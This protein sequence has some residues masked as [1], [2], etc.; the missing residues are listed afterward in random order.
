MKEK[1]YWITECIK[2]AEQSGNRYMTGEAIEAIDQI[3]ASNE[4]MADV[5]SAAL[6]WRSPE[7]HFHDTGSE[8]CD[9][10]SCA[11]VRAVDRYTKEEK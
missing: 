5:V 11:L 1:Y 4:R 8:V 6:R 9:C 7:Y 2:V 3:E 10:K